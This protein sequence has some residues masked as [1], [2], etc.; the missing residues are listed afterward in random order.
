MKK[1]LFD[2]DGT[3]TDPKIGITEC[4]RYAMKKMEKTCPQELTWCIGPPLQ[5]TFKNLLQTTEAEVVEQ[6]VRFFR[7][8]FSVQG[9]FENSVYDGVT[10]MLEHLQEREFQL[11]IATSKP[12]FFADQI[13]EHFHLSKYFI[14]I[15]GSELNGVRTDKGELISYI[16]EKTKGQPTEYLMIGD[17]KHDLIGAGKNSISAIGV[18][19]GYGTEE[20]LS[21][22]SHLS[23]QPSPAQLTEFLM[24]SYC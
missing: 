7:E 11:Y 12:K 2:L 3:L 19:W 18:L 22:F 4:I 13:L 16:L 14:E 6:A 23:L 10:E 17:R 24:K 9:M 8:R 1:L 15:F 21:G 20:E 5:E